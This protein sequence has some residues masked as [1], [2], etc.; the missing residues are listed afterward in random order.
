MRRLEHSLQ[1]FSKAAVAIYDYALSPQR[2]REAL[3][4]IG[5]AAHSDNGQICHQQ[6]ALYQPSLVNAVAS[7]ANFW[8]SSTAALR[9]S[10]VIALA[11]I[12][13]MIPLTL[14]ARQAAGQAQPVE[15][16]LK[17]KPQAGLSLTRGRFVA[18]EAGKA[19]S[20]DTLNELVARP[21][22][23]G[24]RPLF[25][26]GKREKSSA[27]PDLGSYY[28]LRLKPGV[29]PGEVEELRSRLASQDAIERVYIAPVPQNPAGKPVA[30]GGDPVG[31]TGKTN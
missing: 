9:R 28:T 11:A 8:K 29:T 24:V 1:A 15:L 6:P 26:G 3:R 17:L 31:P 22:V 27:Q 13:A 16:V 19:A 7:I 14:G 30:P 18:P 12:S 23:T 10:S 4:L 20:A 2:W 25:S 21:L 5:E